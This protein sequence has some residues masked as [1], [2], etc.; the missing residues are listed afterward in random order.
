MSTITSDKIIILEIYLNRTPTISGGLFAVDRDYFFRLGSYDDKM[1]IW[2][3]E[4][5]ELS[6][7]VSL[8]L[9]FIYMN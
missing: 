2:G 4:N 6:F 8:D 1:D 9:C 3:G 5:I 7:R